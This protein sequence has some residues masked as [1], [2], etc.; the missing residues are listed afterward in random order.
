MKFVNRSVL[1]LILIALVACAPAIV[2]DQDNGPE[3]EATAEAEP[4]A[5]PEPTENLRGSF[6]GEA[7]STDGLPSLPMVRASDTTVC[8]G[9]QTDPAITL[10]PVVWDLH[11]LC[12][13][14][15]EVGEDAPA[16][17][18]MLEDPEGTTYEETF[19]FLQTDSGFTRLT[20]LATGLEGQFRQGFGSAPN[21]TLLVRFDA[22][23]PS[24]TWR[25]TATNGIVEAE[26]DIEVERSEPLTAAVSEDHEG[27]PFVYETDQ[28]FADGD[29][30]M[31]VG[32]GYEPNTR[33]PLA[34]YVLEFDSTLLPYYA[35]VVETNDAGE[36]AAA[37]EV[38]PQTLGL[39]Y[40]VVVD[41]ESMQRPVNVYESSFQV[42][43]R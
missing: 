17:S 8:I 13:F 40:Q 9:S 18:V 15:F 31:L 27:N 30:V 32:Q 19:E 29:Q 7:G 42:A 6:V 11:L 39:Q 35:T 38:G 34:L 26:A 33:L 3:P 20:G 23:V 12:L 24:G 28:V 43:R 4:T 14:N 1:L 2:D 25:A 21:A 36:W 37:F 10:E 5:E 41:P 22:T 16:I